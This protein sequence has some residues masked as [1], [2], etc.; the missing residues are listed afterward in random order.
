M[1]FGREDFAL[2]AMMTGA[3]S[4]VPCEKWCRNLTG[5]VV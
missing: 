1:L 5:A 3:V 2:R 4:D